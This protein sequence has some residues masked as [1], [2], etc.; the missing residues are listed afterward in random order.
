MPSL[1]EKLITEFENL[2]KGQLPVGYRPYETYGAG[3]KRK[4]EEK[5]TQARRHHRKPGQELDLRNF[6]DDELRLARADQNFAR[7]I[8]QNFDPHFKTRLP[9]A[10]DIQNFQQIIDRTRGAQLF[11]GLKN[12]DPIPLVVP[13]LATQIREGFEGRIAENRNLEQQAETLLNQSNRLAPLSPLHETAKS[14]IQRNNPTESLRLGR[15]E[16]TAAGRQ[17]I[18]NVIA[19]YLQRASQPMQEYINQYRANYQPLIDNFRAESRRDFLE[20]DLPRINKQYASRG[21][22]YSSARERALDKARATRED[23]IREATERMM[24]HAREQAERNFHAER[25]HHLS[26]AQVAGNAGRAEREGRLQGAAELRANNA[27]EQVL[28]HQQAVA[29]SNLGSQEQRQ[30]Q[31]ELNVR[32]QEHE[33]EIQQPFLQQLQ[34]AQI[35]SGNPPPMPQLSAESMNP[36]PPNPYTIGSGIIGQMV[37]LTG[38]Q[39]FA[40]GGSVRKGYAAGDSV[41]RAA[42]QL[43]QMGN[44]IQ[45]TP[46]EAEM[47]GSAQSFKNYRAN[48][49]A[50]YLFTVGSHQLANLGGSPMKSFGEGSLLGMQAFKNAQHSNLSAQ[51]KYNNLMSKINQSKMYQREFLSKH[52]AAMQQQEEMLRHHQAQEGETRRGH[53]IMQEHYKNKDMASLQKPVKLSAAERKLQNN[54]RNDLKGSQSLIADLDKMTKLLSESSTGPWI[55]AGKEKLGIDDKIT[56]LGNDI[57]V[58]AQQNLKGIR[59]SQYLME[60]LK[61]TKPGLTSSKEANN[62]L[63]E[64]LRHGAEEAKENSILELLEMGWTPEQIKKKLKVEIPSHLLEESEEGN[65]EKYPEE[66]VESTQQETPDKIEMIAPDGITKGWVPKDNVKAALEAGGQLVQ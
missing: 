24:I 54:A 10:G 28:L 52:H 43:Q 38:Q 47:R 56:K 60:L 35:A 61:S 23:K 42:A 29:L 45:E 14:L 12:G 13:Q 15:E 33:K 40:K 58:K 7:D 20:N 17:N 50:D 9:S 53:D 37:G 57:V 5:R 3:A 22:F 25:A 36:P 34:K 44:S 6:S 2:Q 63:I 59:G 4:A 27:A 41:A 16:I 19:P 62:V 66:G 64:S 11:P 51:E 30:A 18:P 65:A 1:A 8:L 39:Q 26:Q 32:Q 31:N 55:G 49:M 48:P 21:D 46:E